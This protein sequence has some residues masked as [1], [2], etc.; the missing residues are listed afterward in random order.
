MCQTKETPKCRS[1]NECGWGHQSCDCNAKAMGMQPISAK[2][3]N[4]ELTGSR[5]DIILGEEDNGY[6]KTPIQKFKRVQSLGVGERLFHSKLLT[7][8]SI[9]YFLCEISQSLA[10]KMSHFVPVRLIMGIFISRAK[11]KSIKD[12]CIIFFT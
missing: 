12:A 4:C 1:L 6:M 5:E 7:P 8:L 3:D 9:F 2:I 11:E 10:V